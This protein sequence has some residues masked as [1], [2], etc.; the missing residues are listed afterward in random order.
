MWEQPAQDMIKDQNYYCLVKADII[1]HIK[2]TMVPREKVEK[3]V[4]AIKKEYPRWKT[5]DHDFESNTTL[6]Y[7]RCEKC[8]LKSRIYGA[9]K[10]LGDE[11]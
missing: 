7:F 8:G 5:C 4:E 6:D 1:D 3:L 11:G 2:R 10:E 9:L